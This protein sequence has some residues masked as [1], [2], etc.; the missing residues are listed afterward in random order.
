MV[1]VVHGSNA[2]ADAFRLSPKLPIAAPVFCFRPLEQIEG[3]PSNC[4]HCMWDQ[5]DR[6]VMMASGGKELHTYVHSHTTIRGSM[7]RF[8]FIYSRSGLLPGRT[9]RLL[10]RGSEED[11]HV[12]LALI[13]TK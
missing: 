5:V 4:R 8:F 2:G 7:V 6:D 12:L 10:G 11:A 3:F 1:T 9:T 13:Q